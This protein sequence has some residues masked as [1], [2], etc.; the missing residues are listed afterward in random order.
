MESH[1]RA[2]RGLVRHRLY[3]TARV[4]LLAP[5]FLISVPLVAREAYDAT[6]R[7]KAFACL[8]AELAR[9]PRDSSI[10]W[11]DVLA[12][13][14]PEAPTH[15]A[16]R[17]R[18]EDAIL[19]DIVRRMRQQ[20]QDFARVLATPER[21][22]LFVSAARDKCRVR[23]NLIGTEF[24]AAASSSRLGHRY[25]GFGEDSWPLIVGAAA[26]AV[27]LFVLRAWFRWL[28]SPAAADP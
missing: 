21:S 16:P 22:S 3:V 25:A 17:K 19:D 24:A 8:D 7:A 18:S 15:G 5:V 1:Q 2:P 9:M 13:A 14:P 26:P 27:L 28:F 23:T 4:L 10:P 11:D 20:E 6:V 12:E